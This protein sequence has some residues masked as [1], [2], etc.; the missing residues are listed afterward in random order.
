MDLVAE[1]TR[2]ARHVDHPDH[3]R[4]RPGRRLLRPRRRDGEG[5][6]G[7]DGVDAT[8][9]FRGAGAPL[10]PQADAGDAAPRRLSCAT[11]CRRGRS[12]ERACGPTPAAAADA[13][14]P[15]LVVDN[16]VKDVSAHG[17]RAGAA[18]RSFRA[19]NRS[20][21]ADRVPR[22][23]RHQLRRSRAA[24][25]SAS[26]ANPAAASRRPRRW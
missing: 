1:L 26:S 12:A 16:L 10:Y 3:P 11:S 5:Q 14:T 22:R 8:Q 23:R 4:S 21:S 7:R 13:A 9:I 20:R 19:R 25:A 18:R 15:L 2:A 6:C 24:R 17:R